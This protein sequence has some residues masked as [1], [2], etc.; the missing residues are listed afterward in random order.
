MIMS[1]CSLSCIV[2]NIFFS[3]TTRSFGVLHL[4]GKERRNCK[5][6][7]PPPP[8]GFWG[9]KGNINVFCYTPRKRSFYP[10][11]FGVSQSKTRTLPLRYMGG[12]DPS[13]IRYSFKFHETFRNC[14][15]HDAILHLLF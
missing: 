10:Q 7:D 1:C 8:W 2:L 4:K 5:F 12:G 15:L 6:H 14:S 11:D 13:L 3:R 9:R